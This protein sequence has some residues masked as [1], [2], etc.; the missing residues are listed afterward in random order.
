MSVV[1]RTTCALELVEPLRELFKDEV[2]KIGLELGLPREMVYRH[3]FPGPRTR[4]THPRRGNVRNM[5]TCCGRRTRSLSRSC[6]LGRPLRPGQSGVRG[7]PA[8]QIRRCH[9]RRS[10]LRLRRRIA[11]RRDRR[12]HDGTLG[13]SARTISS[14]TFPAASSTRCRAFPGSPTISRANRPPRSSGSSGAV[15][16]RRAVDAA[17]PR[18]RR[19]T[20][21][22]P[23]EVPVGAVLVGR[24]AGPRGRAGI[25]R[26]ANRTRR[27]TPR[28]ARCAQ[29]ARRPAIIGSSI[30][31]ST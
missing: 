29:Q 12:F 8:G 28:S 4:R 17:R 19:C 24:R 6:L 10:A 23:G 20:R 15:V 11:C 31:R 22:R 1:C 9:G 7:I 26:S 27:R 25:A 3:P 2:R 13:A 14:T 16:R 18:T 5:R 21:R 30:R